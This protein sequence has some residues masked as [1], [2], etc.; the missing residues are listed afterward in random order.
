V[1][2]NDHL[3]PKNAELARKA[4]LLRK[5]EVIEGT[6]TKNCNIFVKTKGLT[7]EDQKVFMIKEEADLIKLTQDG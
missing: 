7:P 2:L 5:D 3:T 4:R 6:W 1:Y